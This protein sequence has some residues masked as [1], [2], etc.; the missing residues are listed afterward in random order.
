MDPFS[1]LPPEI[2]LTIMKLTTN[3]SSLRNFV[4]AFKSVSFVFDGFSVEIIEHQLSCSPSDQIAQLIRA[5]ASVRSGLKMYG[6]LQEFIESHLKD[7]ACA[8]PIPINDETPTP[9]LQS[10]LDSAYDIH[11]LA[12]SFLHTYLDRLNKIK[13]SRL[14][15][16]KFE[17]KLQQESW[18]PNKIPPHVRYEPKIGGPPTWSEAKRVYRAL[19]RLQL[20][21]DLQNTPQNCPWSTSDLKLCQLWGE[22]SRH[23]KLDEIECVYNYLLEIADDASWGGPRPGTPRQLIRLPPGDC[24]DITVQS[25]LESPQKDEILDQWRNFELMDERNSAHYWFWLVQ[26]SHT[27]SPHPFNWTTFRTFLRFGFGIWDN[28]RLLSLGMISGTRDWDVRIPGRKR[29]TWNRQLSHDDAIFR[30]WS[31][32]FDD[33]ARFHKSHSPAT[34]TWDDVERCRYTEQPVPA[35]LE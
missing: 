29:W 11:S 12:T 4:R 8:I 10:L 22:G 5:V 26:N 33:I 19:W 31:L 18:G 25:A 2:I 24:I 9:V 15:D 20:F 32:T 6:T 30:W 21:F 1:N 13:P 27:V 35:I 17:F 7:R 3:L 14:L 16:P 28:K 23:W 34:I